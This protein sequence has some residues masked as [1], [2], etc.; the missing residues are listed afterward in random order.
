MK[1][2]EMEDLYVRQIDYQTV[3]ANFEG[4]TF[5]EIFNDNSN[6]M[7]RIAS[8]IHDDELKSKTQI[9]IS[10]NESDNIIIRR[11]FWAL[12]QKI[13]ETDDESDYAFVRR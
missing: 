2:C 12:Q 1:K 4:L 5:F 13:I 11:L 3:L 6:Y 8:Q 7:E 10:G 9:D